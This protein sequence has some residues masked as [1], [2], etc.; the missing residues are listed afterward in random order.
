MT[1][2]TKTDTPVVDDWKREYLIRTFSLTN[3][4]YENY[5]LNAIWH[6]LDRDDI[7]PVTQQYI[8]RS[9]G[10]YGLVD[11][12]FPQISFAIE[13]DEKFHLK[14]TEKDMARQHAMEVMVFADDEA[15]DFDIKRIEAHRNIEDIE[16][17]IDKVVQKIKD[18]IENEIHQGK[19]I[20][21]DHNKPPY[22]IAISN[23]KIRFTDKL[24][25][26]TI[27]DIS[28]SFRKSAPKRGFQP[29]SYFDIGNGY[30]LWCPKLA[31][32][33]DGDV[34]FRPVTKNWINTL[35]ADREE[36]FEKKESSSTSK[37]GSSKKDQLKKD[38][39]E[40][41]KRITFAQS[42]NVLGERAYRFVGVYAFDRYADASES[43]RV[44]KRIA[45]EID[46]TAWL[47]VK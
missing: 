44:Y 33:I 17:Q 16:K 24:E 25:F 31:I 2:K 30:H 21:W 18:K 47:E 42:K 11:L 46:L 38:R 4:K 20:A 26:K 23:R 37:K 8:K 35:S 34:G 19:F 32:E 5:I 9:D 7:Q 40:N 45:T 28:R 29:R 41:E 15:K 43:V 12:Y 6:K 36:L 10:G 27:D 22:D 3:K 1:K 13:C 14:I 39:L